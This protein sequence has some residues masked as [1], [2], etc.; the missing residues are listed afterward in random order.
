MPHW[1]YGVDLY[2]VYQTFGLV[3]ILLCRVTLTLLIV[4]SLYFLVRR[5]QPAVIFQASIVAAA[6]VAL[7]PL[8]VSERPGLISIVFIIWTLEVVLA[9]RDGRAGPAI[10]LLPIAYAAWANVHIQFVHGLVIMGLA[11]LAPLVDTVLGRS[12]TTWRDWRRLTAL[13]AACTLATLCNP[14]HLH[15]YEVVLAYARQK[16]T[17]HLFEEL[18]AIAFRQPADWFVLGLTCAACFALGRR[19]RL[20]TFE[21]L[22][23]L[24]GAYFSF[25]ARHDTW[26]VVLAACVILS[27]PGEPRASATGTPDLVGCGFCRLP[28]EC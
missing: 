25:H 9:L 4:A 8:L 26:F 16:E 2:G 14:Y 5:R 23:L 19:Q 7:W 10:W 28:W 22:L 17:Y 6:S 13:I 12:V 20:D 11:W 15:L 27:G 3:G 18:K 24:A 1:L 21:V